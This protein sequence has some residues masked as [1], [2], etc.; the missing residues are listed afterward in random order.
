V[1]SS[2]AR[3]GIYDHSTQK[4]V[5]YLMEKKQAIALREDVQYVG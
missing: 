4:K 2:E 1:H 5:K 3:C